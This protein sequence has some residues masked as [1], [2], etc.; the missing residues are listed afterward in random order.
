MTSRRTV[1]T[2]HKPTFHCRPRIFSWLLAARV[3]SNG[4]LQLALQKQKETRQAIPR[5]PSGPKC[6]IIAAVQ[7]PEQMGPMLAAI[8]FH[9]SIHPEE[10]ILCGEHSCQKAKFLTTV[11][12]RPL[13]AA[14]TRPITSALWS[15]WLC[16]ESCCQQP[17]SEGS[18]TLSQTCMTLPPLPALRRVSAC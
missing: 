9:D 15:R 5:R 17:A 7:A 14:G 8:P 10:C 6:A 4:V 2:S 3:L 18:H 16:P 11:S 12:S 1:P 13:T